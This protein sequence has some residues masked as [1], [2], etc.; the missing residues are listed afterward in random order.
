MKWE[1]CML[2]EGD[3][4]TTFSSVL[5]S[6]LSEF[7]PVSTLLKPSKLGSL[8]MSALKAWSPWVPSLT[9]RSLPQLVKGGSYVFKCAPR[10]VVITHQPNFRQYVS[11][12]QFWYYD[13]GPV[14]DVSCKIWP[15]TTK[16][17]WLK[18]H[19]VYIWVLRFTVHSSTPCKRLSSLWSEMMVIS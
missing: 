13:A 17:L 6:N 8:F 14:T 1:S 12:C 2:S 10:S 7:T 9:L 19:P 15:L 5:S 16:C 4:L 11:L 18:T 3:V